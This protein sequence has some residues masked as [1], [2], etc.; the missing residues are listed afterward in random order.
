MLFIVLFQL[1]LN[2]KHFRKYDILKNNACY[3]NNSFFSIRILQYHFKLC[4]RIVKHE[5][6]DKLFDYLF[7]IGPYLNNVHYKHFTIA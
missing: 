4:N 2:D 1:Q 3:F 5:D 7:V 6:Y